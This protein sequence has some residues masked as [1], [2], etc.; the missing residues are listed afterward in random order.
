MQAVVASCCWDVAA[1]EIWIK[2]DLAIHASQS[3]VVT[4]HVQKRYT[5]THRPGGIGYLIHDD[6]TSLSNTS[7]IGHI[8]GVSVLQARIATASVMTQGSVLPPGIYHAGG[9]LQ[10]AMLAQQSMQGMMLS[11][12]LQSLPVCPPDCLPREIGRTV[13][14]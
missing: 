11:L 14:T 8:K 7:L 5:S 10:D 9:V 12:S 4:L 2:P 13:L 1:E 6:C 3:P